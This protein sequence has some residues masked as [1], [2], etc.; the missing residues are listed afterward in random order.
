M[1][2]EWILRKKHVYCS[3]SAKFLYD[4]C[5]SSKVLLCWNRVLIAFYISLA[6]QAWGLLVLPFQLHFQ[7]FAI[8]Y[9]GTLAEVI[10]GYINNNSLWIMPKEISVL[11][12]G[13][14]W[15]QWR[16]VEDWLLTLEEVYTFSTFLICTI[17]L[18]GR[19]VL[20]CDYFQVRQG[21]LLWNL[22]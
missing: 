14:A 8:I 11:V 22:V 2:W 7:I 10:S 18:A 1:A 5:N 4:L 12:Q 3:W 19:S 6:K 16:R 21:K 9:T 15:C 13:M 17:Q 20:V